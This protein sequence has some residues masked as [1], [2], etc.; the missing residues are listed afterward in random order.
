[1]TRGLGDARDALVR[2]R[3]AYSG[4]FMTEG[5]ADV[6]KELISAVSLLIDEIAAA[7]SHDD[8]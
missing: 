5:A 3:E 2:A 4:G 1:M 8:R 7:K 6:L